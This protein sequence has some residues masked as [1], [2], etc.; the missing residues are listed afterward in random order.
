MDFK[1]LG[2]WGLFRKIGN[3]K[4]E[5][6]SGGPNEDLKLREGENRLSGLLEGISHATERVVTRPRRPRVSRGLDLSG[7]LSESQEGKE[8][9]GITFVQVRFCGYGSMYKQWG[10]SILCI[11]GL[12]YRNRHGGIGTRFLSGIRVSVL[13]YGYRYGSRVV[14]V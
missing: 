10:G 4:G 13:P 12:E 14:S 2:F 7:M 8:D 11:S 3:L 1:T 5:T 6:D 9:Q